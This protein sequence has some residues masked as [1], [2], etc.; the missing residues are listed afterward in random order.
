VGH[1]EWES[2]LL[3]TI[4]LRCEASYNH[5]DGRWSRGGSRG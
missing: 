2:V 3:G 5:L 1:R 4:C